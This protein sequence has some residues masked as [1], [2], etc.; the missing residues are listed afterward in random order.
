MRGVDRIRSVRTRLRA[1][2]E[3]A[4]V[5]RKNPRL[6]RE[7]VA[8][9]IAGTPP[10]SEPAAPRAA[11]TPAQGT[12]AS[13]AP[14]S[15]APSAEERRERLAP[16]GLS[17]FSRTAHAEQ[18]L[19]MPRATVL[20]YLR[21]L[22]RLGEWFVLHTGWRGE[23][24]GPVRKG[25]NFTQRAQIMGLPVDIEWTVAAA[26]ERG[27]SLRGTAPQ[28]V[29]LGYWIRVS[30]NDSQAIVDF[31]AGLA[32]PPVDGPLGGSVARSV[33]EA[34]R[35][36]LERLPA[37]VAAAGPAHVS[38]K[39]VRH[40]ASGIDLDPATPVLVGA[41][42]VVR[43]S[44]GE[45]YSDPAAL[46]AEA[47]RR[48]AA[49]A[50]G[51]GAGVAAGATTTGD[52]RPGAELGAG[53]ATGD[54]VSGAVTSGTASGATTSGG[55]AT[56]LTASDATESGVAVTGG[57]ATG[58]VMSGGAG[59]RSSGTGSAARNAAAGEQLLQ[60]A[61]AVFAAACA[62]W[63]YRDLGAVV[64]ERIGAG[65]VDTVQSVDFGGDAAQLLINEAAAAIAAGEYEVVLITGAEAGATQALAQRAGIDLRW[66][67][68][69][70]SAHPTRTAGVDKPANN[71]AESTA[72]LIAP[73]N[74]YALLESANRHSL[75]RT[76][77]DHADAIAHLWSRFSS[78]AANNEY[79]W[80]PEEFTPEQIAT[81][82]PDNRMVSTPYTKLEC[83]NLQVDMASGLIMTSVA[84]AQDAGIPQEA[85]I[86]PHAGASGHDEW[87][88]SERADLA[89]SPAIR[90]LGAAALGHA[91]IGVEQL[92]H[93]DLYAC[94][95]VA[96][97][98]AA[99]ELGLPLDDP[100]RPL[101][102]TGGLTFGGG[103][104]N[105]YTGH[106]VASLLPA[107]RAN[108]GGY[109]LATALG[110][111]L[112]KHSVGV[113]S[114]TPPRTG[115]RHLTPIID[116]PPARDARTDYSGPAVIEAYTV[117]YGRDGDPEAAIVSL[118][119]PNGTR[120]LLRGTDS[121]LVTQLAGDQDLLGL[122]VTV[123]EGRIAVT[124]GERTALPDPPPP[125]VLVE[126]RGRVTVITLNRPAVRN[127]V[128]LATAQGIERALDAFEA[129][130]EAQVA[131]ITGA[132]GYFSAG[133]D[134]KAAALGE[135][136]MTA[137]RGPLGIT[138]KPPSKPLIAAVE[139]PALAGGCELALC[140]DLVVAARDST[141]GIP[142]VK[143]GLVAVGGGVLRLARR[144]PRAIAMELALTG[145]PITAAR[146]ADLG[147]V[148]H[149][150]EPGHALEAALAL[151]ERIAVNAPL[152]IQASKRII[153]QTPD[154]STAEEF[155]RQTDLATPAL[156]SQD[157]AEGIL[158]FTQK[159]DPLWQ[160]R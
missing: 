10:A 97:Q 85:W 63:Q 46:A 14:S 17:G 128:N 78:V 15:R 38:R 71:S 31:D 104:G 40:I 82:T 131:I 150:A 92:T 30:G 42:Q 134:L 89:S 19:D 103:P 23:A 152:S 118:I 130:P 24:P 151:A 100:Q 153:D 75:G 51:G 35:E 41:G 123:S 108:P 147:L 70:P 43:R 126:R 91:G 13:Y 27:F 20:A 125:P 2:G 1:G 88:V 26:G 18:V 80:Q 98:I 29:R 148:N 72:G 124:A 55:A 56:G 76:R 60:R 81:A 120:I 8:G 140:A 157:A 96:V 139:G 6:V 49:D 116:T 156:T 106:A 109:G 129:D 11:S 144:L 136:P 69:D 65:T 32:G 48:A 105:N 159:R 111:Y 114:A 9:V 160:G 145:D 115:F 143:R 110:W 73:I 137:G 132:G 37:A 83:A 107:L 149:L 94:F 25:L 99:R 5:I 102:T 3:L 44:P 57:V 33:G 122:P 138:A 16:S 95:P 7:L 119:A 39:P 79:A 117:P 84:A 22:D 52:A 146:A 53:P 74:M 133:M 154:W 54:V 86:F 141:F 36:S 135:V 87:F 45:D 67:A 66:P 47:L 34:L 50:M 58:G 61:D 158:A 113:Y 127:A 77:A 64:A 62:S 90:T 112:T 4:A 68:Q 21:D 28:Q 121:E 142:E 101:S 59:G 12:P 155:T 93:V